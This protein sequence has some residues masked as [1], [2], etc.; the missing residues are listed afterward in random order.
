MLFSKLSWAVLSATFFLISY[1]SS[2]PATGKPLDSVN[3]LERRGIWPT[4]FYTWDIYNNYKNYLAGL[5]KPT[6]DLQQFPQGES[7]GSNGEK[8]YAFSP[9]LDD[10][11]SQSCQEWK[12]ELFDDEIGSGGYG[13]ILDG[14]MHRD[15]GRS[16]TVAVKKTTKD[17]QADVWAEV[18]LVFK[19]LLEIMVSVSKAEVAHRDIKP[20]NFMLDGQQWKAIDF[21]MATS[22]TSIETS[23]DYSIGSLLFTPPESVLTIKLPRTEKV[24]M[25][26]YLLQKGDVF[27]MGILYLFMAFPNMDIKEQATTWAF[28]VQLPNK[29]V[30]ISPEQAE[31]ILEVRY[32]EDLPEN[33]RK[34][35]SNVFCQQDQRITMQDFLTQFTNL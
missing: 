31:H 3:Y 1:T 27:A 14:E 35:L 10:T 5:S 13:D 4:G 8:I 30:N 6:P 15:T 32:D 29:E 12:V 17:A 7:V 20:E 28:L 16:E 18:D 2:A 25:V 9:D 23:T 34:L 11:N 33:K 21:D 22:A 26:P 19:Q 24:R